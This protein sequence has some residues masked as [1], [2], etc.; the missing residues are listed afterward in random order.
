MYRCYYCKDPVTDREHQEIKREFGIVTVD[1]SEYDEDDLFDKDGNPVLCRNC[2]EETEIDWELE[3]DKQRDAFLSGSQYVES[4]IC[5]RCGRPYQK[6][7]GE[8]NVS[9][10]GYC[11]ACGFNP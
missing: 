4:G 7:V 3:Y 8:S 9:M 1:Y 11:V 5:L 2:L 10:T 6:T